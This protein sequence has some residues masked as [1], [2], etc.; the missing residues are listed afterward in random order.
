MCRQ[1]SPAYRDTTPKMRLIIII[2]ASQATES[3]I[4][5]LA[6]GLDQPTSDTRILG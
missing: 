1:G 6:N 5:N 2:V 3:S 4:N